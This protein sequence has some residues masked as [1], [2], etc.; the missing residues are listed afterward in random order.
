M[1]RDEKYHRAR[2]RVKEI[3]GFYEHLAT[4]ASVI[5]L[6]FIIDIS[7][8][9]NWWCYWPAIGWGIFIVINGVSVRA[10]GIF[11][12]EWEERKIRQIMEKD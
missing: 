12:H 4:Y 8:G 9:G 7:D 1:E 5:T 10:Q 11:S 3:R 6:L 2:K